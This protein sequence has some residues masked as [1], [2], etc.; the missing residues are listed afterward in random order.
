M[1][2]FCFLVC[3]NGSQFYHRFHHQSTS[4]LACP[5]EPCYEN[6]RRSWLIPVRNQFNEK[7]LNDSLYAFYLRWREQAF[8]ESSS[9][10]SNCYKPSL[11]RMA[12]VQVRQLVGHLYLFVYYH[13]RPFAPS[14]HLV[15]LVCTPKETAILSLQT[16]SNFRRKKGRPS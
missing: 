2:L 8:F 6:C 13:R 7:A 12:M 10:L 14:H 5:K 16:H 1:R 9:M 15:L 3:L 11:L 4:F